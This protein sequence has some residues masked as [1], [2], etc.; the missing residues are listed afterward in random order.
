MSGGTVL[1]EATRCDR[2]KKRRSLHPVGVRV[3]CKDCHA[4]LEAE[5]QEYWDGL[6][7]WMM[8][9]SARQDIRRRQRIFNPAVGRYEHRRVS[10]REPQLLG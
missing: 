4:A 5:Y 10:Q 2:C 1:L 3:L 8:G 9:H 6:P 7:R